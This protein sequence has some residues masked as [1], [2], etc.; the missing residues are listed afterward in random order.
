MVVDATVSEFTAAISFGLV[1]ATQ[2]RYMADGVLLILL[3]GAVLLVI[4][5]DLGLLPWF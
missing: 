1:T 3:F 5:H 2:V 4:A